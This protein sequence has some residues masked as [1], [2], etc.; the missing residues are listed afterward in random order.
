VS[1]LPPHRHLAVLTAQ[2]TF[3]ELDIMF[4]SKVPARKFKTTVVAL[5]TDE[6]EERQP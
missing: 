5:E 4:E 3:R 6:Q 2:R 1:P